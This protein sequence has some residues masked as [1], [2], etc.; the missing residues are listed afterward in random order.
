V[1][2]HAPFQRAYER[3]LSRAP[4]PVFPRA[5]ELY[6]RKYC[7]EE[8]PDA[9]FRTFLLKEEIQETAAGA[10]RSRGVAFAVVHWHGPQLEQAR[11]AAY[12]ERRW[13]LQPTDLMPIDNGSWFRESG[14]WARFSAAAVY[15]RSAPTTLVNPPADPGDAADG[16]DPRR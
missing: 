1:K 12:L 6:L 8:E 10:V 9:P 5:R 3:L 15:E 11:Y 16:P 7:L 2:Q 13:Q 14:A 4:G